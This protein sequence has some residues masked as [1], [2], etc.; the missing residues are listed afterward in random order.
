[1]I[2]RLYI[3]VIILLPLAG[4][5]QRIEFRNGLTIDLTSR[6]RGFSGSF[7]ESRHDNFLENFFRSLHSSIIPGTGR[8]RTYTYTYGWGRNYNRFLHERINRLILESRPRIVFPER[9]IIIDRNNDI[10]IIRKRPVRI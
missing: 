1:M 10:L 6:I 5:S 8:E 9:E 3:L 4:F 2:K 7:S